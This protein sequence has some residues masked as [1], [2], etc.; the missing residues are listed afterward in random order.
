MKTTYRL[1]RS[2]EG[3]HITETGK[4]ISCAYGYVSKL[5]MFEI[6][7][8]YATRQGKAKLTNVS[9]VVDE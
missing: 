3:W 8:A 5:Q 6:L 4:L 7:V 9:I 2:R 1:Y